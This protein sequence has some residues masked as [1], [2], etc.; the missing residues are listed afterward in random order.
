MNYADDYWQFSDEFFD[1][2]W[3]L[4]H[5]FLSRNFRD[6]GY[7]TAADVADHDNMLL[8]GGEIAR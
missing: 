2:M 5:I 3:Y 8:M 7:V 1:V 6:Y 4:E